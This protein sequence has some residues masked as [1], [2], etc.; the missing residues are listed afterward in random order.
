MARE[1]LPRRQLSPTCTAGGT[2]GPWTAGNPYP[3]TIVR[4][5]FAQTATDFYVF[6]GV[7]DGFTMNA[8]NK[9]NLAS[10]TWTSLAPM[11][12]G[13]EAPTC[14]LDES[15]GIVY[16]A[17]GSARNQFAAYN[18][19]SNSWTSLAADPYCRSL[20][21]C[22]GFLQRQGVCRGWVELLQ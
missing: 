6:G 11:P 20:R 5:G 7:Y 9:Y 2:P 16:C 13:N 3:T 15:G 10:G 4:Y 17:D 18:I 22:I 8:V 1:A 12:F 21:L 14:A 19:A